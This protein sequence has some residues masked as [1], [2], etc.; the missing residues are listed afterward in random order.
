[1]SGVLGVLGAIN[2]L[3]TGGSMSL[4]SI[5][6][7][8]FEVPERVNFGGNQ[9]LVVH[10]LPGGTRI[11]DAMG[12]DPVKPQWSG[13]LSGPSAAARGRQINA[14]RLAAAPVKLSFGPYSVQVVVERFEAQFER[15][16]YWIPYTIQCEVLPPLPSAQAPGGSALASLIGSSAASALGSVAA[17]AQQV[18]GVI[19]QVASFASSVLSRITPLANLAG[20]NLGGITNALNSGTSIVGSVTNLALAPAAAANAVV[21]FQSAVSGIGGALTAVG[22]G[23]SSI[24]TTAQQ[25]TAVS[26][27]PPATPDPVSSAPDLANASALLGTQAQLAQAQGPAQVASMNATIASGGGSSTAGPL[28]SL[29]SVSSHSTTLNPSDPFP[30]DAT[31]PAGMLSTAPVSRAPA[32]SSNSAAGIVD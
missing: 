23:L 14:L 15:S 11:I 12:D 3:V 24:G 31:L 9:K 32:L 22:G 17:A 7:T 28:Q 19:T 6:F 29:S 26:F 30:N 5:T 20:I 10:R 18:Q 1:M 4:G 2:A 13:F 8:G 25:V 21:S 16:G 27:A